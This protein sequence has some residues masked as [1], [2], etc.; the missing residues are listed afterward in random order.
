MIMMKIHRKTL[1]MLILVVVGY[2]FLYIGSNFHALGLLAAIG[3]YLLIGI[4]IYDHYRT[5]KE[6]KQKHTQR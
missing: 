5:Q 4:V 2:A 1:L 6:W 3:I